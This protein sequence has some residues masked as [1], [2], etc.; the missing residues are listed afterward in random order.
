VLLIPQG[1][2]RIGSLIP[3]DVFISPEAHRRYPEL[4]AGTLELYVPRH[5]YGQYLLSVTG[6]GLAFVVVTIPMLVHARRLTSLALAGDPFTPAMV[7]GLRRLGFLVLVGGLL[8]EAVEYGASKIL[9]SISLPNDEYRRFSSSPDYELS[10]SWLLPSFILL[11]VSEVVRRGC[12][13]RAE[14]DT[15]I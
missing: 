13:L 11:A 1:A 2:I 3:N 9:L 4:M 10:L 5:S 7:R 14:L 15:V 6:H 8:A 12:D